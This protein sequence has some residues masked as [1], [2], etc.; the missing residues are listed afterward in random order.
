MNRAVLYLDS[1]T[2]LRRGPAGLAMLLA[3]AVVLYAGWNGDRWRDDRVDSL[4][5]FQ[6]EKLAELAEWR[7]ALHAIER[8]GRELSPTDGNPM[9]ILFP[10]VLAPSSLGDFAVGHSDL[11]PA[12]A[13]ISPWRNAAN[14][15]GR[16]QF[17]NPTTIA[18]GRF[19]MAMVMV[20][21]MPV[22]MIAISF[23]VVAQERARGTLP[24][25]MSHPVRLGT[26]VW[27]RLLFRNGLLWLIAVSAMVLLLLLNDGDGDRLGR[28]AVWLA[29]SLSYGLFW[30]TLI[31]LVVALTR[32]ATA[33]AASLVAAWAIFTLA[34]PAVIAVASEALYATPSRLAYLSE[35]RLAQGETNRELDRLTEGFLMEHPDLTVSDEQV[36]AYFRATYLANEAVRDRTAPILEA[37]EQARDGR[38]R[39]TG[40]A[41]FLSPSVITQRLLHLAAG[42]DLERQHRYQNQARAALY[43][44]SAT[45]GPAVVSR[46]RISVSE[47]DGLRP[48]HFADRS[49]AE[50]AGAAAGPLAYL[51][52]LSLGLAAAAQ[53]RLAIT[54]INET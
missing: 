31:A 11:Q 43:T 50:L 21:L 28:F 51:L 32:S 2:F 9:N 52:L 36:P 48:F 10:A 53:R 40:L 25:V 22:L 34:A 47:F 12:A 38:E 3:A 27:T 46:N 5:T 45:V 16:Y 20:L 33:A 23:D 17:E 15:F 13:E 37:Y 8:E 44:L 7:D 42:A 49:V 14:M 39:L 18:S 1:L 26:I 54:R 24:M 4:R 35:A 19:D 41:Q 30:L 29:S 6:E